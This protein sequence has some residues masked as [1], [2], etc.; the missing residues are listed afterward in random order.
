ML[1]LDSFAVVYKFVKPNNNLEEQYHIIFMASCLLFFTY[2]S[3]LDFMLCNLFFIH[4]IRQNAYYLY[5]TQ[6][7]IKTNRSHER[8]VICKT[9]DPQYLTT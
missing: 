5:N 9:P 1:A 6:V 3:L 7:I 8:F 2:H 4:W